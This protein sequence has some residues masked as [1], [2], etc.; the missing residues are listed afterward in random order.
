MHRANP[1]W[2]NYLG[3]ID[4]V[5]A[6]DP[7]TKDVCEECNGGVL[8]GL[9]CYAKDL[10]QRYFSCFASA[11]EDL[12]FEYDYDLLARWLLKISYNSARAGSEAEWS[13]LVET[14][15][16]ILGTGGRPFGL[17]VF[18]HL[19]IPHPVSRDEALVL[20]IDPAFLIAGG[21]APNMVRMEGY[22]VF[23]HDAPM[24]VSQRVIIRSY[25]FG[26]LVPATFEGKIEMALQNQAAKQLALPD[27]WAV[28]YPR[29]RKVRVRASDTT[30]FD[31]MENFVHD[32]P[33]LKF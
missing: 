10:W 29:N 2:N 7:V 4:K 18:M 13:G 6:A 26:L 23:S 9:D 8:S 33:G 19:I 5:V 15:P 27:G 32:H 21:I 24:S 20:N 14:V 12:I 31:V 17:T 3:K 28:L 11:G 16:Y 25:E 30:S 1:E 22:G